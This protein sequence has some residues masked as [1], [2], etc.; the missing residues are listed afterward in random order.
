MRGHLVLLTSLGL[1]LASAC[2]DSGS[3][4][5]GTGGS[6]TGGTSGGTTGG[7]T[8]GADAGN[9]P[10]GT[11]CVGNATCQSGICGVNGG[12]RCCT[13]ACMTSDATCKASTCSNTGACVYPD[14]TTH[15]G[16][17]SCTG[18][19]ITQSA[20]DGSGTCTTAAPVTC[21]GNFQCKNATSCLTQC[22]ATTDCAPNFYCNTS[23]HHCIAQ[24]TSGSC[25]ANE[26][27]VSGVCGLTGTGNCCAAQCAPA[28][29]MACNPT[30]CDATTAACIYPSGAACGT[31]ASCPGDAGADDAGL[32]NVL[33]ASNCDSLGACNTVTGPCPNNLV[34]NPA[35]T[36]C[37]NICATTIDCDTGFYCSN[38]RCLPKVAIGA[39]N[40][41]EA[42]LSGLCGTTGIGHCCTALCDT[43]D[44][45][46]GAKDCDAQGA[47][48]FP[49]NKTACGAKQSCSGSTQTDATTCDGAGACQPQG[50]TDCTP[51]ICGPTACLKTCKD[52]SSC[53]SGS[54]CDTGNRA[55]CSGLA[56]GGTIAVD[57][58]NGSDATACCGIG[59]NGACQTI[60]QAM[61]LIDAAQA[62]N[63]TINATVKGAGGDWTAPETYPIVLG[64]GAELSAPGVFFVDAKGFGNSSI[65]D[66]SN[67]STSDMVG[68]ASIVGTAKTP[69]GVGM[70]SSG[71]QLNDT[72]AIAV[73]ASNTLYL[74]NATVN[75]SINNVGSSEAILVQAGA[76]LML[77]QDQSAGVTGTVFIGNS[78]GQ[79]KTNGS[80]G[81]VCATDSVSL[82][83]TIKDATLAGQ[84]SVIIQGQE[85]L[86]IDAED[87]ASISLTSSPVIGIPPKAAGFTNC[88]TKNDGI[89]GQG[90]L[91]NGMVSFT[92]NNGTVQCIGGRGFD[93]EASSNGTPTLSIDQTVIQNTDVG[94]YGGAGSTTVTNTTLEFNYNGVQQAQDSNGHDAKVD[95]SGGG[96]TVVCN[97]NTESSKSNTA[98]GIAVYNTSTSK[99]NAS[100]VAWDTSGP[101]YFDCDPAFTSCICNLSS[102]T[103]SAGSDGMDAVEDST[104]R[105]GVTTTSNT[106]SSI[107][108]N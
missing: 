51:Y 93:L 17:D 101:D 14:P 78:L 58:A 50:T 38:T 10:A 9:L 67:Y 21:P 64:W 25:T 92:F 34:C 70:D 42:C 87:F 8:G 56:N 86:D 28:T 37:L 59:T 89:F 81:I 69:V 24:K 19:L 22:S 45:T 41:N 96:N 88:P 57:G 40:T 80:Q 84:S 18:S 90:V 23:T 31:P 47:C 5:G 100:N 49:N 35:G 74:A 77:G 11:P 99:L 106:L 16:T 83:C 68:Y 66:V 52:S 62:Q 3:S 55:C 102:C 2:G 26:V 63:V 13:A 65:F 82:G 43:T 53:T 33:T 75:G 94:L 27:C 73:E 98:P 61:A 7:T 1:I 12:G 15:C 20:C 103:V 32:G 6:T 36:A 60:G 54:F 30:A 71:N 29:D 105:G 107:T 76:T 91:L 104:S 39:C 46:C 108:C 4:D 97:S 85:D 44:P 95:L 79:D 48:A 72:A